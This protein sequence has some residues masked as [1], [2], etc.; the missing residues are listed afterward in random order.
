MVSSSPPAC[1]EFLYE[2]SGSQQSSRCRA[3]WNVMKRSRYMWLG[4]HGRN[5]DVNKTH[6]R[7]EQNLT[8][9]S[10]CAF[11]AEAFHQP[12]SCGGNTS[13]TSCPEHLLCWETEVP[14]KSQLWVWR[15]GGGRE[16]LKLTQSSCLVSSAWR[17]TR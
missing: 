13:C 8:H 5:A 11:Q 12:C 6:A 10:R 1:R 16:G 7:L 4:R 9:E 2:M 15:G 14:S 3:I 17:R